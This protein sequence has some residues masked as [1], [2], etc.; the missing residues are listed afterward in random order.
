M[1]IFLSEDTQGT[2]SA[3]DKWFLV[4]H[5]HFWLENNNTNKQ[6]QQW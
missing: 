2:T 3:F 1:D 6:Q 4:D 5:L